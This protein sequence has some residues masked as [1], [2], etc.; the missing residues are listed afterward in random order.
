MTT[1]LSTP[2]TL[3]TD[4]EQ[5]LD[6]CRVL[7]RSERIAVDTEADSMHHYPERV[8]LVQVA[9]PESTYLLDPFALR[10][11][12]PLGGALGDRRVLKLLHGADYDVRGLNRDWGLTFANIF[13]TH[14]A[15]Q[16]MG[17]ERV[18]LAALL[19][20][21]LDIDI[22]KDRRIQRA[23][24]S[25]RPLDDHALQYA[26]ADVHYLFALHD[27]MT[28]RLRELGRLAWVQ[29]ECERLCEVRHSPQDL[30]ETVLS[31]PESRKMDSRQRAVLL[32]LY[33]WREEQARRQD[34]P[35]SHVLPPGALAE[36]AVEPSAPLERHKSLNPKLAM[37]FGR[38]IRGV[39]AEGLSG[40]PL[41]RPPPSSPPR[42]RPTQGQTRKLASLK[43][44][45][46]AEAK[47]IEV[48]V[49][50]VWP[51]RSLERL[52]REPQTFAEELRSPE[53][54]EWQRERFGASLRRAVGG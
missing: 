25:K 50:L 12:S 17:L 15:G 51:M 29:E 13:D 36:I 14:I 8:C 26:A 47:A 38:A 3:V 43:A 9:T 31:L 48:H 45:R 7:E 32:A 39:V 30:R 49:S 37:R 5:F 2:Y 23:D 1:A 18:G 46:H 16:F 10:D 21:L 20:D 19:L 4:R 42:G 34:R 28:E 6:L 27:V 54:R 52:A 53:V 22:P 11:L 35:P 41:E 24:W 33:Q 40:P 44:W